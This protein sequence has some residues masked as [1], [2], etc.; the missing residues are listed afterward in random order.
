[1]HLQ[2]VVVVVAAVAVEKQAKHKRH[3]M[4][5]TKQQKQVQN[6]L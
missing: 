5:K 4:S 3:F 6:I 2:F 1:V